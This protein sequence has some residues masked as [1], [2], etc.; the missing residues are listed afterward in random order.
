MKNAFRAIGLVIAFCILIIFVTTTITVVRKVGFSKTSHKGHLAV[1]E[2]KG[3]ITDASSFTDKMEQALKDNEAKGVIV[4]INSPGG[5]VGPSQEMYDSIK[6][7]NKTKPVYISMGA[8]AASGGY[9][10]AMG[11]RKIYA[12]AGTL[13][14]SVGVIAEF[15]NAEKL[16]KWAK[17][18]RFTLK[19]GKLKDVGSPT[20]EMTP[21]ER[22]FLEAMLKDIHVEFQRTVQEA[23]KLTNEEVEQY[24]DGR[25]MTGHQAKEAKLVDVLGSF[26][27]AAADLKKAVGLPDDAETLE[28][29]EDEG[30]LRKLLWGSE[31]NEGRLHELLSLAKTLSAPALNSGWSVM[32]LAPLT[33]P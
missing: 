13:T 2:L 30:V 17:V 12:N 3:L 23:R 15:I 18:D 21:P 33:L 4:R 11:G 14:A 7:V 27:I 6:K 5:V 10:A 8:V 16:M 29:Q 25:V 22:A 24:L 32:L 20:R 31:G 19:A 9:Y 1:V 26:D 28:F